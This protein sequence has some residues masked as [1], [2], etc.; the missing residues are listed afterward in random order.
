[1]MR[2]EEERKLRENNARLSGAGRAGRT[3]KPSRKRMRKRD[4]LQ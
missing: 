4:P 3:Q 1:M 2:E